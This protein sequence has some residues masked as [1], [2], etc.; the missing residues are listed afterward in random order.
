M[1]ISNINSTSFNTIQYINGVPILFINYINGIQT[2]LTPP[3][4]YLLIGGQFTAVN[5]PS[6]GGIAKIDST[7]NLDFSF[8]AGVGITNN[9]IQDIQQQP[10]GKYVIGGSF[11]T[12]SGSS[13]NAIARINQDGSRDATFGI[14]GG[15]SSTVLTISPQSDNSNVIGGAFS[16]YNGSTANSIIKVTPS[17]TIDTSFN[18][19]IGF[20]GF[21]YSIVTQ[22]D[23]KIIAGGSFSNYYFSN[24]YIT[25]TDLS[26]SQSTSSLFNVGGGFNNTV[27]NYVTQSDNKIIA[28]GSFTTYSGSS[29]IR[30]VR[31]NTDGTRD[32]TFNVGTGTNS[33][34][35]TSVIQPDGKILIGGNFVFYSGSSSGQIARINPNG[36]LDTTF[37]I[38]GGFNSA[39]TSI[40]LQPDG[41]II[42]AGLFTSY[43]GSTANRIIRINPSGSIDNTFNPGVGFGPQVNNLSLQPD[44]KI[45]ALGPYTTYSGS[46]SIYLVRI[47][48]DGTKDTTFSVGAF[49]GGALFPY[50]SAIEP[51]TNKILIGGDFTTYSGSSSPGIVRLNPDGT[52]D[53]TFNVGLGLTPTT[54]NT[55]SHVSYQSDGKIYVGGG[56]T[57]YSGSAIINRFARINP[58]GTLDTS[59]P[60]L[61]PSR[62]AGFNNSVITILISSSNIYFG[63]NF[64]S[65]RPYNSIV[66]INPNGTPDD[67]FLLGEGCGAGTIYTLKLQPDGKIIAGGSFT[68]YNN[69][70]SQRLV[71]INSDGTKDTS[72]N[73]GAINNVVY[74]TDIQSDGK[75]LIL[76]AFNSVSGSISTSIAR[77]NVSGTRDTTFNVGTGISGFNF[78]ATNK[79]LV[80]SDDKIYVTAP[81][82]TTY[83]GSFTGNLWRINSSG[84]LDTTFNTSTTVLNQPIGG[85]SGIASPGAYT[86]IQSGSSIIAAGNVFTLYKNAILSAGVMIDSTGAIS[87]SFNI[88][89]NSTLGEGFSSAAIVRT[90]A[91]QS[92]GKII[93]GGLFTRYSGSATNATRIIRLNRDGTRDTSFVS[94]TGFN[95]P[96]S[97]IR[98]QPDGKIIATGTFTTY[99]GSTV[100]GIVRLNISGTR[101]TSFNTGAGFTLA[102][103]GNHCKIQPDGKI[104]VV[105]GFTT[106]SG[107]S[108]NRIV[109]INTDGTRDT[110]FNVG[111]GFPSVAE[112]VI[113]QPDGKIVVAGQFVSYSGS[114]QNRITRINT[115]GTRDTSFNIGTGLTSTGLALA[116]QSDNKI[117]CATISQTYSGSLNRYIIRI[118]T[119]GT[120]DT[121]FDANANAGIAL[122]VTNTANGLAIANDG[123]I[124]WGNA[125]RTFSGSFAPNRIVRLNTN[126][127]VDETF[128]Q[129]F[130]NYAD[131]TGKGMNNTV[132]AILLL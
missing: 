107:S 22:P 31:I 9:A 21:I 132:N 46:S 53:N 79:I 1:A 88:G 29:A 97:D 130:P 20:N 44:G 43:S 73:H 60:V 114:T 51:I 89:T 86:L 3:S 18:S 63:G 36:T 25:L 41:K 61:Q 16:S 12:Y 94:G 67:T 93:A 50:E 103:Q 120:L 5:S 99:S 92:D 37:N 116:L 47:N 111:V 102:S 35:F 98:I 78:G 33:N 83:S 131:G 115:N 82:A 128:N 54:S 127:S 10:D 66:R 14:G 69:L 30:I 58:S 59:F 75:V 106:Y 42:A 113:L 23:G 4:Q 124:Y 76:G 65:Y 17:G 15:F 7:G 72:F 74:S 117:I 62:G 112:S 49:S 81:N 109:R 77:M 68:L 96:V 125:F 19:G 8:N 40:L 56:F 121:T 84:T 11:T 126:G 104:V 13:S 64:T 122:S 119:D 101:D 57:Q 118:N 55:V 52:R 129:A 85:F 87:S 91:T 38:G 71:R 100:N 45:I 70:S 32:T 27:S 90:W 6:L 108:I 110:S 26:G 80:S 2:P 34:L 48:P 123:K 95:N 24:N 105:G 28:I 39:V